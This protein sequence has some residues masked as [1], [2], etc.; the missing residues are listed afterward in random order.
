M[1]IQKL[2]NLQTAPCK[3]SKNRSNTSCTSAERV[4]LKRA[5]MDYDM[6]LLNK[7]DIVTEFHFIYLYKK[8]ILEE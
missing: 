1:V 5:N 7:N 6:K 4:R 3:W 8:Y 2:V